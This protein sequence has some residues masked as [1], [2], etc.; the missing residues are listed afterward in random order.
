MDAP[1][2]SVV[3]SISACTPDDN[4]RQRP[5][6]VSEVQF[7]KVRKAEE[8]VAYIV[9]ELHKVG[10]PVTLFA[11][12][13][14]HEYRNGTGNCVHP[15][16]KEDDYDIAVFAEHFHYVVLLI[17]EIEEK[18]GWKR[19]LR[20]RVMTLFCSILLANLLAMDEKKD[21]KS[22]STVSNT[23]LTD[24]EKVWFKIHGTAKDL[25]WMVYSLS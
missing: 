16:L 17:D 2:Q 5:E 18:F 11:G 3:S 20:K 9:T 4:Q 23:T 15:Y 6:D 12:T 24:K 14:L 25:L 8:I 21:F 1:P 19:F 7:Q 10:A 22:T 13:A